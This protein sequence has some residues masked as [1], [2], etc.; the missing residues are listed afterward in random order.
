MH[1]LAE[2]MEKPENNKQ[3]QCDVIITPGLGI[4]LS[5]VLCEKEKNI[6]VNNNNRNNNNN[7]K[8]KQY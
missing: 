2:K 6:H 8:C 5:W 1:G 4:T 3:L 7:K